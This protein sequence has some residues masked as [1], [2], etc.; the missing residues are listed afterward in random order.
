MYEIIYLGVYKG[1]GPY[2][3]F[4]SLGQITE[5]KNWTVDS[6]G[7]T[8]GAGVTISET[9]AI[10]NSTSAQ[11][12]VKFSTKVASHMERIANL[13]VRNVIHTQI[14]NRNGHSSAAGMS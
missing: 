13:P 5:L 2:E 4:V 10:L 9:I 3:A 14:L 6:T 11:E 7:I 1:D 8:V 12:V